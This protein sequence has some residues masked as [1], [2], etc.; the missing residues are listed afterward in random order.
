MVEM[1][2]KKDDLVKYDIDY[3]LLEHDEIGKKFIK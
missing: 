3:L 1:T 2:Q